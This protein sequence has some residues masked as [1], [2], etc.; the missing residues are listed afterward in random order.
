VGE[1]NEM[2]GGGLA[3]SPEDIKSGDFAGC[4]KKRNNQMDGEGGERGGEHL[5]RRG[6]GGRHQSIGAQDS[7]QIL[8]NGPRSRE[9]MRQKKGKQPAWGGIKNDWEWRKVCSGRTD[10][11]ESRRGRWIP[12]FKDKTDEGNGGKVGKAK[13]CG[14]VYRG[15]GV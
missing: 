2:S 6:V 1:K 9:T 8:S 11:H 15:K 10:V 12:V 5:K 14:R 7:R 13:K 3:R 4:G